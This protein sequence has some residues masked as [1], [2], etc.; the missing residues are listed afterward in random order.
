MSELSAIKL[1]S[2]PAFER[3]KTFL[4]SYLVCQKICE[5]YMSEKKNGTIRPEEEAIRDAFC[6]ECR[7]RCEEV[8]QFI[9]GLLLG[10]DEKQMLRFHYLAGMSIEA[11]S[12][13]LYVSRSTAFR[14]S[15]RAEEGA[16]LAFL[17]Y[18]CGQGRN[19]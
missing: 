19:Q 4:G 6:E 10:K 11:A 12:E 15:K 2:A 8:E 13:R 17:K 5:V 18:E 7:Q 3:M 9:D 14:I 16:L 1:D